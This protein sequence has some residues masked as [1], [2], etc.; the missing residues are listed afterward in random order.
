MFTVGDVMSRDV[1]TLQETDGLLQGDELLK[2]HRIRHLPVVRDGK[3][4]GI[5]SDRDIIRALARHPATRQPPLHISD[6]MTRGLETVRPELPARD[7]IRK[8]LDH[9]FG[10]LPVVEGDGTLLGIVT[11]SDFMRLA[12]RLLDDSERGGEDAPGASAP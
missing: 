7:A 5:V 11:E 10:C 8:L 12:S 2:S 1:I 6:I 3:L 4:V 9:R